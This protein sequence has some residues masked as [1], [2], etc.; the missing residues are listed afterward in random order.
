MIRRLRTVLLSALMLL[1]LCV[2][3]RADFVSRALL[4]GCDLFV[5]QDDTSPAAE[6]NVTRMHA[7]LDSAVTPFASITASVNEVVSDVMLEALVQE[8]FGE[9]QEGD[10]SYLYNREV[11]GRVLIDDDVKARIDAYYQEYGV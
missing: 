5:S 3:A 10:V 4:I 7:A 6:N 1:L 8:T 9:A 2:P 11:G